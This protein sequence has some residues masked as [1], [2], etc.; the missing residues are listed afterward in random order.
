VSAAAPRVLVTGAGTGLGNNVMR[1]L[2][3]AEGGIVIVGCHHDRFELRKSPAP[4]NYLVTRAGSRGFVAGIRRIVA[5]ERVDVVVPATDGDV[6]AVS[7]AR[8]HVGCRVFLP[9]HRVIERCQDKYAVTR[10]LRARGVPAPLTYPVRDLRTVARVFGRLPR[11]PLVWCRARSGSGSFAATSVQTAAHARAWIAYWRD[12]RDVPPAAFTLCEYLPGRDFGCQSLWQQG[13]LVLAKTFERVA[14]FAG[15]NQ[16]SGVS[17]VASL[18]KSVVE[19]RVVDVC[20]AAVRAL[21]ARTCGLYCIDLKEND[22]GVPCITD[23]NVGRFSLT[24]GLYDLVGKHNM[25]GAYVRLALG[26]T[27][28]FGDAYDRVED[29]YLVRDIDTLPEIFH[30]DDL[31]DGIEDARG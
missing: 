10:F 15:G 12:L 25:A 19:P 20:A 4:R 18:A 31:F 28:D 5:A 3:A 2:R 23:V 24:T 29:H 9:R 13:R 7:H 14:Y 27:I 17:S 8:R 6:R 16:P 21:D 30:A 1:S 26:D 22:A 11:A